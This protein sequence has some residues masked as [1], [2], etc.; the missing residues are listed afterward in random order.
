MLAVSMHKTTTRQIIIYSY[1]AHAISMVYIVEYLCKETSTKVSKDRC[2]GSH[3]EEMSV[4][5]L[6]QLPRYVM[7]VA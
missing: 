3:H 2:C 7:K 5:K 4:E 1:G 6:A